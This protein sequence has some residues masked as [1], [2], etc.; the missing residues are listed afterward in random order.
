[1]MDIVTGGFGFIGSHLVEA[2]INRGRTVHIIDN[3]Y[4]PT[5]SLHDNVTYSNMDVRH[6]YPLSVCDFNFRNNKEKHLEQTDTVYHLAALSNIIPSITNP[7]D[8]YE[9]NVTGT[10]NVLEAARLAGVKKFVYAASASCYG[11]EGLQCHENDR[12]DSAYPYALTKYLGEQLVIHYG[13]VY[14]MEV[15]SL[16]I[17]NCYGPHSLTKSAYGAMFNT[18]LA[19]K[20]N[21]KPLTIIGDGTQSRDFVYVDDVV[22]AFILAAEKGSGIYNVGT[23]IPTSI[24]E[25]AEIIGGDRIS[26]PE[27]AGEPHCI[28][29]DNIRLYGLGWEP[30]INIERGIGKMLENLDYWKDAKVW[31]PEAIKKE[32]EVWQA[33]LK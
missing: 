19:Q 27:R 15:V 9:T 21:G 10:F 25:V 5:R 29:A 7:R 13:K 1:M 11:E 17:F 32:T 24:N 3:N 12:C 18:F 33:C 31:E 6:S 26:I 8:Y 22:E 20:A 4:Q 16:R 28:Y 23:G 30:K 2:L 14:G